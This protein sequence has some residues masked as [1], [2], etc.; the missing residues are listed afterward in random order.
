MAELIVALDVPTAGEAAH[1]VSAL[2]PDVRWFKVGLELYVAEGP[3]VLELVRARGGRVMLDLKLCD[4]P[5]TVARAVTAAGKLWADLI[6]LH[7]SGGREMIEKAA[8]VVLRPRLLGVTV[9]TSSAA[10]TDDVRALGDA[11]LGAGCD[12]IVCA[13][14]EA[15]LFRGRAEWI[16]TPGVRPA[17]AAVQ[18]HARSATPA[19]AAAAGATH[20]VVGRPIRDAV[21]P[22][23]AA[24]AIIAEM[25]G[26]GSGI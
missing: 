20:V 12:G 17:D 5:E 24:K 16:V 2:V 22:R 13:P 6:T 14:R 23:A 18:D 8:S 25:S 1:L 7:A 10:A 21:D 15:A 4:I 9:L 19:E 26:S 3:R 11:A